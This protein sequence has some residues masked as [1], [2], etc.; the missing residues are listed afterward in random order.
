VDSRLREL[1]MHIPWPI[2]VVIIVAIAAAVFLRNTL[3]LRK[4]FGSHADVD[5]IRSRYRRAKAFTL[6]PKKTKSR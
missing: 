4:R 1:L 3:K 5:E 2:Y 6:W